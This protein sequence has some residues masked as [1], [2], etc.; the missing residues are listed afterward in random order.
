MNKKIT[1]FIPCL[2]D[3]MYPE[4]GRAMVKL[5]QRL[6]ADLIYPPEQTCC[7]QPG[8]NSG[9]RTEARRTARH[10]IRTFE[11][12]DQVVC[13]SGSCVHMVRNHYPDLFRT[14][15][16]W[17]ERAQKIGKRIFEL[18]E[19]LVDVLGIEKVAAVY[20]GSATYHDSCHL[21]RG[22]GVSEQPRK[23]IQN[24]EGL[25][26]IEMNDA[27]RCC[28]FGGAFAVNYPVI[29]T[30]MVDNKVAN[31][32]ATGADLVVGCDIGCLM[33]IQG[34]LHRMGSPIRTLHIAQ[35]L[36]STE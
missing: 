3:S 14:E 11:D 12:A 27:D 9:F 1:L 22:I 34:R 17:M 33:N 29:S 35:L 7:G 2:V 21:L 36:A 25:Q 15:P 10:F 18:T 30:A 28:G 6:G 5:L 16:Q 32:M 4:V 8:F 31:I 19:Y 26:L 24:V 13:P 20:K 23:L